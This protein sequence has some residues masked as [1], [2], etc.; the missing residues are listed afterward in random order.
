VAQYGRMETIELRRDVPDSQSHVEY[1]IF[2]FFIYSVKVY[3]KSP[4]DAHLSEGISIIES[5]VI[6]GIAPCQVRV[7]HIYYVNAPI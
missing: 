1:S 5:R 4:D 7:A 6:T 2:Q 3:C